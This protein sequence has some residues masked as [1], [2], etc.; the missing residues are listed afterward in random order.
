MV[1]TAIGNVSPPSVNLG[2]CDGLPDPSMAQQ[3]LESLEKAVRKW[4]VTVESVAIREKGVIKCGNDVCTSED[5]RKVLLITVYHAEE[6]EKDEDTPGDDLQAAIS[7][8]N[9]NGLSFSM[10]AQQVLEFHDKGVR[11]STVT[12]GSVELKVEGSSTINNDVRARERTTEVF[13]AA[14]YH[15]DE[16]GSVMSS[17]TEMRE[18]QQRQ[19]FKNRPPLE[20]LT[21][22]ESEWSAGRLAQLMWKYYNHDFGPGCKINCE[23]NGSSMPVFQA[24]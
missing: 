11:K 13:L 23:E 2:Y 6:E 21:S 9:P 12:S 10:S 22:A 16:A 24:I 17:I 15:G 7:L 8:D 19:G 5:S 4:T 20:D 18:L 14:R 1:V 3:P